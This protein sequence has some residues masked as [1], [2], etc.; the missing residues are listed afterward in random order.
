MSFG[1]HVFSSYI[2]VW[3]LFAW[4]EPQ[5]RTNMERV[6]LVL[7]IP[8]A[9][10]T[11][12]VEGRYEAEIWLCL[13]FGFTVICCCLPTYGPILPKDSMI[14]LPKRLYSKLVSKIR[15]LATK[16]AMSGARSVSRKESESRSPIRRYQNLSDGGAD[17]VVLTHAARGFESAEQHVAGRDIP[18]SAISIKST[19]EMV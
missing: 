16:G 15:A 2:I 4:Y 3:G 10:Y 11:D 19:V 7:L 13:Q 18:L 17:G 12:H 9:T 1:H 8:T 5:L 6:S 14:V